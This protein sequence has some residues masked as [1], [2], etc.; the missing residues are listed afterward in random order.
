MNLHDHVVEYAKD[1]AGNWKSGS[2]S[3]FPL[4]CL[5]GF[6]APDGSDGMNWGV[7]YTHHRDN[8]FDPATRANEESITKALESY[9]QGPD[10]DVAPRK[11]SHWG[12]GWMAGFS[13]RVRKEGQYTPA[14]LCLVEIGLALS[15]H[16]VLD[17]S[18]LSELENEKAE[19]T[20]ADELWMLLRGRKDLPD[21]DLEAL[22]KEASAWL[23][24]NRDCAN[25]PD[26]KREDAEE[27]LQALRPTWLPG[28][29]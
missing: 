21:F 9:M 7:F 25:F 11:D 13:V 16:P 20:L 27:A 19:N 24:D 29:T 6:E 17:E 10:P 14:F 18:R 12:F 15:E 5:T 26:W 8:Q 28:A 23:W 1:F 22:A 2:P 4:D 3:G